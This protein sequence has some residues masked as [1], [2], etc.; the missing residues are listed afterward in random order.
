M[1]LNCVM[2]CHRAGI[3]NLGIE[4]PQEVMRR[5]MKN[6]FFSLEIYHRGIFTVQFIRP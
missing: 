3:L 2:D 4:T 1:L 6:A 5:G